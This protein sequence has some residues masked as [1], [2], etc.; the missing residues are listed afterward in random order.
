MP[1]IGLAI[2][3]ALIFSLPAAAQP[4]C[5][6]WEAGLF[7]RPGTD[8]FVSELAVFDDGSGDA[9][10]VAGQFKHAGAIE[11]D[12]IAKWDGAAFSPLGPG[13]VVGYV[14]ALTA[15]D[16][17]T[18]SALYAGGL[19]TSAGGVPALSVAKWDGAAWS[20]L[21]AGLE[22]G[23][24]FELAVF[25]DGSGPSLHAAGNFTSS[26]GAPLSRVAKWDGVNWL[27]LGAGLN[28]AAS[29]LLVHDDGSGPK[30][31]AGGS[32]TQAGGV[33]AAHIASWDGSVWAPLDAGLD[34][35]VGDLV[36]FDDGAGPV[37]FAVGSFTRSG[38]TTVPYVG[39]WDGSFWSGLPGPFLF[40]P[41]RAFV[42]DFT[43]AGPELVVS[44]SIDAIYRRSEN[45][46]VRLSVGNGQ[47]PVA[48]FAVF[49][50]GSG[51]KL[52]AGGSFTTSRDLVIDHFA[53]WDGGAWQPA[54]PGIASTVESL[55]VHDDGG[56]RA[57]FAGASVRVDESGRFAR[58]LAKW[59]GSA[60]S[61]VGGSVVNGAVRA[62]AE[63]G[64][65][66]VVGG[67]FTRAG[68]APASN[69]ARWDGTA[70]SPLGLGLDG[71]VRALA[72][73]GDSLY[74]GG[75]FET[76]GG[77]ATRGLARWDG[78]AWHSVAGGITGGVT[79]EV[80]AL[81]VFDDGVTGPALYA[82]GHFMEMG[83]VP[84]LNVA[85]WDGAL[86]TPVG[87]G[88]VGS[89]YALV[90]HDDGS[91]T[92][93][94]L[95]AGGALA[96]TDFAN[97]VLASWDGASWGAVDPLGGIDAPGAVPIV[98]S[99]AVVNLG[100]GPELVVGG[101]FRLAGGVP[102]ESIARWNGVAWSPLGAGVERNV[103][104][105]AAFFDGREGGAP[106]AA[107]YA[108]GDFVTVSGGV[109]AGRLARYFDPCAASGGGT[110]GAG[111]GAIADVLFVNGA[112]GGV[113][114]RVDLTPATPLSITVAAP[115]GAA[116]APFSLYGFAG[117]LSRA[118]VRLVR[119]LGYTARP[120]PLSPG[121]SPQLRAIWNNTGVAKLGLATGPSS[122]APTTLVDRS[123]GTGRP[124]T[125]TLQGVIADPGS[126]AR[127]P[128]SV[129]NAVVVSAR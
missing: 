78:A 39:R 50:G 113:D 10:Y 5:G 37:L 98:Y 63:F 13:G 46:W 120:T 96:T 80:L 27:P 111:S 6:S 68:G 95:V 69:V 129:T 49:D 66:L 28:D 103:R 117:G 57:L 45:R 51:P 18:G 102:A 122:A 67:D 71:S 124:I 59:S 105:L 36:E 41:Y 42:H 15:F 20:P 1:R 9:L 31:F 44:E 26:G 112:T 104:A 86:I 64:G 40:P 115:P 2:V 121:P 126:A 4:D 70:F 58:G 91:G 128:W 100:L 81:A 3:L 54:I 32:F 61:P 99:M 60:W 116:S 90:V 114:R 73:F 65:D 118:D 17:G 62:M 38:F 30:L 107:L 52:Y 83:G 92:G 35:A 110:V 34:N 76:A 75:L 125:F 127:K 48:S 14:G 108:G 89:V 84:A 77:V 22:G 97:Y 106:A 21:G 23:G 123:G 119:G 88:L 79:N 19:F 55:L 29:T 11:V 12:G 109:P 47:S 7:P 94:R 56:G 85:R 74:A 16:D 8:F 25:D 93:S 53:V 82:A 43:G 87:P 101:F 72:V 33:G 24:V